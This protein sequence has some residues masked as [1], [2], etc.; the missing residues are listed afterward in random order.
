MRIS[1]FVQTSI[2]SMLGMALL[3]IIA[4][5]APASADD[6]SHANHNSPAKL[7]QIVRDTTRAFANDPN[8]VPSGYG[9][10]FGCISGPDHGA[11]GVHYVNLGLV[12]SEERRVGKEC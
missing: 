11:M 10:V 3:G 9:P 7:V 5:A 6:F 2:N 4:T 1:N 12:R 8:N